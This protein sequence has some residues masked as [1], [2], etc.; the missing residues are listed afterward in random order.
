[1]SRRAP[2]TCSDVVALRRPH[3]QGRVNEGIEW[4]ILTNGVVWQVYHLTGGLP[5]VAWE[6]SVE[7]VSQ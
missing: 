1:M 7:L 2:L 3:R 6:V 4:L 5:V